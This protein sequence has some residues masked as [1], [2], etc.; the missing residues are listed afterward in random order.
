MEFV[1]FLNDNGLL[2]VAFVVISV[3]GSYVLNITRKF[4]KNKNVNNAVELLQRLA[5]GEV[6]KN[7]QIVGLSNHDRF[8]KGVQ[9]LKSVAIQRGFSVLDS[10]IEGILE[11]AYQTY[12]SENKDI[13]TQV[14]QDEVDTTGLTS[15]IPTQ[16]QPVQQAPVKPSDLNE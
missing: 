5:K 7:S 11:G 15:Y 16:Q 10:T 9:Y 3:F 2:N 14:Q 12:K 13:H 1:K 8:D 6:A 4:I